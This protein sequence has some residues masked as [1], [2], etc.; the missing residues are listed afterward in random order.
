MASARRILDLQGKSEY[1]LKA[2]LEWLTFKEEEVMF[3]YKIGIYGSDFHYNVKLM[4]YFNCHEDI[5]LKASVFS[6][7]E[8]V[9]EYTRQ[10]DLNLLVLDGE[11]HEEKKRRSYIVS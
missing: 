4:E 3:S 10:N 2:G 9:S 6:T 1:M 8:S 7:W 5:P 11:N